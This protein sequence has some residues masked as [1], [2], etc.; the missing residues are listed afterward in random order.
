MVKIPGMT[1]G[2]VLL[3]KEER[4]AKAM[5]GLR[6]YWVGNVGEF[7]DFGDRIKD[8]FIDGRTWGSKWAIMTPM[9]WKVHGLGK[10][11][12]GYGQRYNKTPE[13]WLKVEG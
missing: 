8:E 6:R 13:G 10:L 2:D 7:D 9:S 11:G 4:W 12:T 1:V 3:S 5:K